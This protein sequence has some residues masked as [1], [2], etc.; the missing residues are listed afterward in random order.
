M[1][2]TPSARSH[3]PA[4]G[5][6]APVGLPVRMVVATG[7][8]LLITGVAPAIGPH[9]AGLLSPFPAFAVILALFTHRAY[10]SHGAVAVLDGLVIGL[11]APAVFFLV[12]A[13]ALPGLGLL[14]FAAAAAAALLTQG[15]TM[16]AIPASAASA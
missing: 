8:V 14:A 11:A 3:L 5:G 15:A 10:G 6:S 13:G 7:V 2:A 12:L 9:W 1:D 4:G 16:F